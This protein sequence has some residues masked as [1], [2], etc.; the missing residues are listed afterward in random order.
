[1]IFYPL[2]KLKKAGI[3]DI[4]I[5]TGQN[6][7]ADFYCLLGNG[8]KIGLNLSY[9]IQ[10]QPEGIVQA[11]SLAEDFAGGESI[12]VLLGDNIFKAD[13]KVYISNY[14]QQKKGARVLLKEVPDPKRYGI[15][16]WE[17]EE[18][19][20]IEEKPRYPISNTCVTGIYMYDCDVFS[21]IKGL[22]ASQRE[23]LEITDVNNEYIKRGRLKFDILE[24]WWIDAGTMESLQLAGQLVREITSNS[25]NFLDQFSSVKKKRHC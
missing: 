8:E 15:A 24:D 10:A 2:I 21:I 9:G 23:Q 16:V 19:I 17:G 7:W 25:A 3:Y 6:H 22:R 18:I 13:L 12:I 5:V 14:L 20:S 4:Y 1:M 11:L